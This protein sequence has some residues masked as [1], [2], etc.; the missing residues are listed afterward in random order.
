[1]AVS[2]EPDVLLD[3]RHPRRGAAIDAMKYDGRAT[4]GVCT[5]N[6]IVQEVRFGLIE[7]IR[8]ERLRASRETRPDFRWRLFGRGGQVSGVPALREK[9]MW[10][11]TAVRRGGLSWPA[12]MR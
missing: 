2:I 12:I 7:M 10:S 8:D 6:A 3:G 11:G 1:M 5:P 9:A 4:Q